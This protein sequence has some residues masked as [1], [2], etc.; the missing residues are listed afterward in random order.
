M[1]KSNHYVDNEVFLKEITEYRNAVY[2]AQQNKIERPRVPNYIGTC[3]FKIA[4]HLSRRPNFSRYTF[5]EDMI[6]DGVEN[7]LLYIDNFDPEK[8][9]NPFAYFTQIIYFAFLRR[10][11]K[12]KKHMYVKYKS[13]ENEVINAL[14]E[15]T[16][17]GEDMIGSQLNGSMHDSYAEEFIRDFIESFEETKRKK[18]IA[19]KKKTGITKFMEEDDADT[20][21]STN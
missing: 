13:M 11:Q 8:S 18:T 20:I 16:G 19:R 2:D 6:S 9:K 12:E 4:T 3:L 7:C 5:R 1:T 10:I 21:A 15:N 14:I 17:E